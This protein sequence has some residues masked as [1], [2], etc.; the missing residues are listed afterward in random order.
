[1]IVSVDGIR[2]HYVVEGQGEP[3]LLV[4]GWGGSHKSLLALATLLQL[5]NRQTILV[6]LPG[7]GDSQNPPEHW[8]TH[9]YAACI[10]AILA[11]QGLK[12][13]DYFGHSYGGALGIYLATHTNH[14]RNLILCNSSYKRAARRSR[15][16]SLKYLLKPMSRRL[17]LPTRKLR[18]H[19]YKIFFRNSDLARYPHLEANF[20]RIVKEDLTPF[21]SQISNPTLILW[22]GQDAITP[23]QMGQDLHES[24]KKSSLVVFPDARHSL[25]LRNPDLLIEPICTF[26]SNPTT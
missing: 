5:K 7:F 14:I 11:K 6:D 17:S 4:H 16:V 9:E 8:G 15:L 18:I 24:I 1:M 10:G 3:I 12:R 13:V 19:F 26:L 25:P 21:V 2:I 22:G 23:L 20:R